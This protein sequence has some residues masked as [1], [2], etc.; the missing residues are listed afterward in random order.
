MVTEID[1]LRREIPRLEKKFGVRNPFVEL[2]KAQLEFLQ[3]Q[4]EQLP[5]YASHDISETINNHQIH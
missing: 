1:L 5:D 3:Y 4:G 2:L